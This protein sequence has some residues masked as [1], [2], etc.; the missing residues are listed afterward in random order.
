MAYD[1]G[2]SSDVWAGGGSRF[3]IEGGS[4]LWAGGGSAERLA[5]ELGPRKASPTL[6]KALSMLGSLSGPKLRSSSVRNKSVDNPRLSLLLLPPDTS[7]TPESIETFPAGEGGAIVAVRPR[8]GSP[9]G[10]PGLK[11]TGTS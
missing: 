10:P 9:L 8:S 4:K 3:R 2:G 7:K 1:G 5:R 6:L 11:S